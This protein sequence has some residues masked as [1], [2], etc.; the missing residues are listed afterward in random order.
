MGHASKKTRIVL[1]SATLACLGGCEADSWMDPSVVGRWEWTPTEVPILERIGSIEGADDS[2]VEHS[3]V[4]ATDLVPEVREY[5]VEPGDALSLTIWDLVQRNVAERF[6]PVIDSRGYI[7][8]PQLGQLY[9]TGQSASGIRDIIADAMKD[10]VDDPLIE[11]VV[12]NQR[13]QIFNVM[14]AVQAPGPYFIPTADY[15]LLEALNSAGGFAESTPFVYVIRQ[16]PLTTEMR[17]GAERREGVDAVE[18]PKPP[19]QGDELLRDVDDITGGGSPGAFSSGNEV[20]HAWQP[21][22]DQ[23]PVID[24][25]DDQPV[26]V[27]ETSDGNETSW[28][29]LNGE[30][31]KVDRPASRSGTGSSNGVQDLSRLVTQRVIRVPVKPLLAGDA[32]Y[33]I[34]VRPGDILRVPA[35]E[36][37]NVYIAGFVNR[38]GVYSLPATGRL[39]LHRAITAA[40]G[41]GGLAIPER[42]DLTRRTGPT[43]EATI[44]LNL[45]AIA[46]GTQPDIFL[47]PDDH[48]NVGTNFWAYPLA[49]V[50][51][52]FRATYGFGFLLDRNFGND[53]FGAPPT[54]V[55]NSR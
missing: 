30:W 43:T 52:G 3:A 49:V 48:I 23:A 6:E 19:V 25:I 22:D 1:L 50:R 32:R 11:V 16:V 45:R 47:K 41:L 21:A 36:A 4:S 14:G 39:T 42:V 8:I 38:P 33:N 35:A 54:N 27:P 7:E 20:G 9:V 5:R 26:D 40:G 12:T 24:L 37:G 51:G 10:L 18:R 34:V 29:F 13:Q 31:V 55:G 17:G 44:R 2:Y 15:R 46:E 28:M 53:V